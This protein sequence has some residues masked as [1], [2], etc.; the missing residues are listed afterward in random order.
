MKIRKFYNTYHESL[1]VGS[2]TWWT[3]THSFDQMNLIPQP[4]PAPLAF[5]IYLVLFSQY[6]EVSSTYTSPSV[7][8]F[9]AIL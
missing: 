4:W 6:E 7:L 3:S 2:P 8:G 5:I 9:L 1:V